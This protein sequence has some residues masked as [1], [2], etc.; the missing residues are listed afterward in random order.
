[1]VQLKLKF[2]VTSNFL[3][4]LKLILQEYKIYLAVYELSI[5]RK[6]YT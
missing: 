1:M 4:V 6:I 3:C 2:P 5:W